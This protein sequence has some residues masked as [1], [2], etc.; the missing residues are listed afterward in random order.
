MYDIKLCSF[1]CFVLEQINS[2]ST[3]AVKRVVIVDTVTCCVDLG[4]SS[5]F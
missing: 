3:P 4:K 1:L 5:L 2:A